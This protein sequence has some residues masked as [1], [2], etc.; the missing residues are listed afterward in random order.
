MNSSSTQAEWVSK[1]YR[2]ISES[3]FNIHLKN[4][5]IKLACLEDDVLWEDEDVNIVYVDSATDSE[6]TS[7]FNSNSSDTDNHIK[8]FLLCNKLK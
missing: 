8:I 1:T 4:V 2:Q 7:K 3:K 5:I 6:N